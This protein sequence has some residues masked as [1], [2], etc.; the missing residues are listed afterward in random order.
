LGT[1]KVPAPLYRLLLPFAS[2]NVVGGTVELVT[3]VASS[4]LGILAAARGDFDSAAWH[5]EHALATNTRN[6]A[7]PAA[8]HTHHDYPARFSPAARATAQTTADR[9][10]R[11]VLR[12]RPDRAGRQSLRTASPYQAA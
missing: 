1:P 9:L 8:A 4:Y 5:F 11:H 6:G 3:G 12:A 2:H 10:P 7:R